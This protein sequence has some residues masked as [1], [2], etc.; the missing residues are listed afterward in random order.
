MDYLSSAI[1][2]LSVKEKTLLVQKISTQKIKYQL[3]MEMSKHPDIDNKELANNLN[4]ND[5]LNNL[6]TLK[7]RLLD[8]IISVKIELSKNEVVKVKE[9]IQNLRLLVYSKDRYT[10]I[11]E[12]RKLEKI[13]ISLELFNELKEV[14]FC[15]FLTYRHDNKK[16]AMYLKIL[17]TVEEKQN[18]T[19]KLEEIFYSTVLDC[20]DLFYLPNKNASEK[21]AEQIRKI[22]EI[23]TV[24]NNKTSAFFYLSGEL[25]LKL[26]VSFNPLYKDETYKE[27]QQLFKTYNHSFLIYKY[28]N[29]DVAIQCLYSR[30]YYLTGEHDKFHLVHKGIFEKVLKV[31]G[32]QMFDCS[33][34]YFIYVTVLDYTDNG[35]YDKASLFIEEMISDEYTSL[36]SARLRNHYL[37]LLAIK[38]FYNRNYEK[39]SSILL[40]SRIMFNNLNN[41]SSW[42]GIENVL[43][44]ILNCI[45]TNDIKLIESETGL[46][47]RLARKFH[48]EKEYQ[49]HFNGLFRSI[50]QYESGQR[51]F[52][53][54]TR[55]ITLL[56]EQ[57]SVFRLIPTDTDQVQIG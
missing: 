3:F 38:E 10:L 33:F 32:Y 34:F 53:E 41:L 31:K 56:K 27:L 26:S 43:L 30:Y 4:Y 15:F 39:S 48:Y 9:K 7:N 37:Y 21:V 6:Y 35:N 14:Y 55:Q 45:Y 44:N 52:D 40:R 50:K 23:H 28:P 54:I 13:C 8:D 29:C 20:Q 19:N 36:V 11:R 5:G 12:L 25:T 24:L 47:K 1:Q 46:F 18:L 22:K 16:S 17:K 42:V 57:F 51:N 2:N 49:G